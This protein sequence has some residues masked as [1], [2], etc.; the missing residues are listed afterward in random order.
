MALS[1]GMPLA[2]GERRP[3]QSAKHLRKLRQKLAES[4]GDRR[5]L[6]S[7]F[8]HYAQTVLE[9]C[10]YRLEPVRAKLEAGFEKM[11][12]PLLATGALDERTFD[13]LCSAL[14]ADESSV[15]ALLARY[16]QI[17]TDLESAMQNPTGARRDRNVDRALRFMRE[18]LGEP[19]TLASVARAA[20]FAPDYFSKLFKQSEGMTFERYLRRLRLERAKQMLVG[21]SLNVEGVSRLCGFKNRMYFHRAFKIAAGMTPVEFRQ[22]GV[23]RGSSR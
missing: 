1:R 15:T 7:R 8:E 13:D 17:V 14:E 2:Y 9:H 18:H 3:E 16:R 23:F 19:L 4:A 6:S 10:G 22:R 5:T 12:E 21:S 20:G 11:S